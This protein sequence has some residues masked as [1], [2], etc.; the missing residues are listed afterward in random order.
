MLIFIPGCN[1]SATD[2]EIDLSDFSAKNINIDGTVSQGEYPFS[3]NN[4][5]TGIV[6][7]WFNDS[8][9]LYICLESKSA[10]WTA[11]GFDP[12]FVKK[13]AN[14]ILFAMDGENVMVRDDFGVSTYSHS[15]DQ[16]LG[17]NSDITW[18]AG[19]KVGDGA[20]FEFVLPLNSG[21]KFDKSLEPG[22]TYTVIFAIN[23]S[24]NDFDIKHTAASST[25]IT[26][27]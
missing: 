8:N 20:T 13:N 21:D 18:Y 15:S 22:N 17:G 23:S 10:G 2:E 6:M 7:H 16:D 12:S 27:K 9:N 1:A 14:I 19:K 25:T 3:H 11:I 5:D 26:L 24:D 4:R